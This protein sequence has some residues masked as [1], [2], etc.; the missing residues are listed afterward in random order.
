MEPFVGRSWSPLRA[1]T[2]DRRSRAS[3]RPLDVLTEN[4]PLRGFKLCFSRRRRAGRK[5]SGP[6][7]AARARGVLAGGEVAPSLRG[8][9]TA[10]LPFR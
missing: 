10:A 3:W 6:A 8:S 9:D 1:G 7:V 5:K 2:R 4:R